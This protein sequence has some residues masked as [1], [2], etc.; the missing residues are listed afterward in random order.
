MFCI[1]NLD[2]HKVLTSTFKG[3]LSMQSKIPFTQSQTWA[4][5]HQH[6]SHIDP[7][8]IETPKISC[9]F[10]IDLKSGSLVSFGGPVVSDDCS[11]DE[12]HIFLSK[13]GEVLKQRRLKTIAFRAL[14]PLR[15]QGEL[16][17]T[18]LTK[19]N[20][21]KTRWSTFLVDLSPSEDDLLKRFQHSARKGI[22]KAERLGVCAK[23]CDSFE[24]YYDIFLKGYTNSVKS[25][26]KERS[27]QK[28]YWDL[29]SEGVYSYWVAY[30]DDGSELGY[31]G[32]Y[33]YNGVATEIMSAITSVA[34]ERK[35][36]VQDYLHWEIMK[37]YKQSGDLFFD[38]A[39]FNPNP[40]S[41]K[42]KNIKRFKEK[43]GGQVYDCSTYVYSNQTFLKG[44][45]KKLVRK[46]M[47]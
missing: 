10:G 15:R 1:L 5:I 33:S 20:F 41:A 12:F 2:C 9:L 25:Q 44:V 45:I 37:H 29:D 21:K 36:P 38:L 47:G 40:V 30:A 16:I 6:C 17:E 4:S 3:P 8:Y 19:Q 34:I 23:R 42:E 39:G 28:K 24:E 11:S 46:V 22:K 43:W 14:S 32:A 26:L 31:L 27:F 7:L 13:V 18:E 35:I